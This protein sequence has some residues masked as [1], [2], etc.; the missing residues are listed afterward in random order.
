MEFSGNVWRIIQKFQ[1]QNHK[2]CCHPFRFKVQSIHTV[3]Q[4]LWQRQLFMMQAIG[5]MATDCSVHMDTIVL[6]FS[7]NMDLDGKVIFWCC[8]RGTVWIGFK[9]MTRGKGRTACTSVS[10]FITCFWIWIKNLQVDIFPY[11]CTLRDHFLMD[12][13]QH[14]SSDSIKPPLLN[15]LSLLNLTKFQCMKLVTVWS[16]APQALWLIWFYTLQWDALV[17]AR[18]C[19][20]FHNFTWTCINWE[21]GRHRKWSLNG[22][23]NGK[24]WKTT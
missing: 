2:F 24:A 15:W 18:F 23:F 9:T 7:C 20:N 8:R 21:F 22:N 12:C 3:R 1:I 4:R 13:W 5:S 14:S 10:R 19:W 11:Q 16:K 6:D 17:C